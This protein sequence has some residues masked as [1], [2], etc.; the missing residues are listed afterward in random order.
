MTPPLSK[1]RRAGPFIFVSGQM[2]RDASGKIVAGNIAVQTMQAMNNLKAILE[3][4][5]CG[6]RD[7][8]KVTAWLAD[9][10]LFADFNRTYASFFDGPYPARSTLVGTLVA[11]DA[12]V[13]I[14]AIACLN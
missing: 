11:P 6:L 4:H 3:S 8:V 13:E 14:E 1:A 7:I 12:L 9:P 2:P 10:A 5:G